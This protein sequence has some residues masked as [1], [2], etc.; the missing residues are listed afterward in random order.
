MDEKKLLIK[1]YSRK[2]WLFW[3]LFVLFE[4]VFPCYLIS[5]RYDVFKAVKNTSLPV[6]LAGGF[7]MVVII[8]FT[9]F[10]GQ[11]NRLLDRIDDGPTKTAVIQLK[12]NLPKIII[13]FVLLAA[14]IHIKNFQFIF[15][16]WFVS[17]LI[18]S[19]FL[20][21]SD[22]YHVLIK[23]LKEQEKIAKAL[24]DVK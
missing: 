21:Y 11:I 23:E 1:G 12:R 16:W 2:Q 19:V 9:F 10:R 14:E 3:S 15:L 8:L 24:K 20:V 18:A 6:K 4:V 17:G 13:Y 7:F 22:R 5:N